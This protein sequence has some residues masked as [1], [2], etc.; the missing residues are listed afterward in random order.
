MSLIVEDGSIVPGAL[1]YVSTADADTYHAARGIT[2]WALLTQ[3][4]KEQALVRATDF[5]L[6]RYR[7]LWKGAKVKY[8]QSLDWPRVGVTP[9]DA[10]NPFS[11]QVG[12]GYGYKY[13]LP[14][15]SV[16]NEVKNACC[17]LALRAAAGPLLPDLETR[18]V[19]ET[20]GPITT[21]YDMNSPQ[22]IRYAQV[23]SILSPLLTSG[24]SGAT[25]RLSRT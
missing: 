19:Q 20:V 11:T 16:P 25:V 21:R 23:D 3:A 13:V 8:Q 14:Y 1:S 7:G 24:G 15:T 12:Y 10:Q 2:T 9:D 17:E 18:I 22:F 4:Q 6:G 5:M